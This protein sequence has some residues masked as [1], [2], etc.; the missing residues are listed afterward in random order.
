VFAKERALDLQLG[1][2]PR[3]CSAVCR[4]KTAQSLNYS[5]LERNLLA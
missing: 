1:A 4:Q 3:S 5:G 2:E